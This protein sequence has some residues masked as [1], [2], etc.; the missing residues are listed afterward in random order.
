M[1]TKERGCYGSKRI[2]A[3]LN[4]DSPATPVNHKGAVAKLEQ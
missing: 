1:F 2:T 4:D 3:E